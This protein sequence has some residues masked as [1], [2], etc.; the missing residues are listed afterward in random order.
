MVFTT[1][2]NCAI[3]TYVIKLQKERLNNN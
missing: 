2:Y 3:I 1:N